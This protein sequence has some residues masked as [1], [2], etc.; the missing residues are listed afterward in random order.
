MSDRP[1]HDRQTDLSES[2]HRRLDGS[3]SHLDQMATIQSGAHLHADRSDHPV[4]D[5]R[6][7]GYT[8][9]QCK[10]PRLPVY[11]IRD[12]PR[13]LP[14]VMAKIVGRHHQTRLL[15]LLLAVT[16]GAWGFQSRPVQRRQWGANITISFYEAVGVTVPSSDEPMRFPQTFDNPEAE[17]LYLRRSLGW[18]TIQPRHL[19]SVGLLAGEVFRDGLAVSG[20]PLDWEL[21]V[22]SISSDS[23]LLD[24][25]LMRGD[26]PL[27]RVSRL[28]VH[29]FETVALLASWQ[30]PQKSPPASSD[31]SSAE[32]ISL[33]VTLTPVIT[34]SSQLSSRPEDLAYPCD[35]Y[36]RPLSLTASDI[37]IPPIIVQRVVPKFPSRRALSG[38][39]LVQGVITPEGAITNVRVLRTFDAEMNAFAMDAFR[40]YRLL[41]ARLNGRPTYAVFREEIRF[42]AIP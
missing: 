23:V 26:S 13:H 24:F 28:Q 42:Q 32:A 40:R 39:V 34:T 21:T 7:A 4:S 1:S 12:W 11:R 38:T 25:R 29:N 20:A 15:C 30:P 8:L 17:L 14:T 19:R 35:E 41:P 37:F 36:G 3:S 16:T 33:A 6:P 5:V 22:R 27:L 2:R 31:R 18:E 10:G 9:G